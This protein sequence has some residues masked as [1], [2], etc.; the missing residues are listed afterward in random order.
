MD[1]EA[2]GVVLAEVKGPWGPS[3]FAVEVLWSRMPEYGPKFFQ[4][5]LK[6]GHI[7]RIK[8]DVTIK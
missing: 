6:S 7:D 1:E 4:T 3:E 2:L 5:Y 8:C